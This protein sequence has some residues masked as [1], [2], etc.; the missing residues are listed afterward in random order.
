MID[1]PIKSPAHY[2][3]IPGIECMDVT[4]HFDF[5]RGAAIKYIWRSGRKG[6]ESKD[7]RKA[8]EMLKARLCM[9]EYYEGFASAKDDEG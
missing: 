5:L 3:W 8:I 1:D 2:T 6:L 4:A 9:A 7:L